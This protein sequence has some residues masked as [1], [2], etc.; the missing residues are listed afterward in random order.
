M[1]QK[2]KN[3][4]LILLILSMAF[5]FT[6]VL[7]VLIQINPFIGFLSTFLLIVYITIF[8]LKVMIEEKFRLLTSLP[9]NGQRVNPFQIIFLGKILWQYPAEGP[10]VFDLSKNP[11]SAR[12][13]TS[14]SEI[15]NN[16]SKIDQ[17]IIDENCYE[18]DLQVLTPKNIGRKSD[19][20][21]EEWFLLVKEWLSVEKIEKQEIFCRR[22]K[23]GTTRTFRTYIRKYRI[24]NRI[25]IE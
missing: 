8:L 13:Q 22:H 25:G 2:N 7:S 23:I 17:K 16:P 21:E 12:I 5:V 14:D 1:I 18:M 4:H 15:I 3:F 10:Y 19:R 11:I 6:L 9:R 24:I 20:T